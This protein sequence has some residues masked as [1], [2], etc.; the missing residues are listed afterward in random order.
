MIFVSDD[1]MKAYITWLKDYA[2][3]F[4]VAI[5]AWVLMTNQVHNFPANHTI[6]YLSFDNFFR[7]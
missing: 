3:Q 1:D 5:H 4:N 2:V 6:G 7:E